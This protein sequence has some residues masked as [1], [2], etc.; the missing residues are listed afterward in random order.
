M[1]LYI[2][3]FVSTLVMLPQN[4][5]DIFDTWRLGANKTLTHHSTSSSTHWLVCLCIIANLSCLHIRRRWHRHSFSM[6]LPLW[7]LCIFPSKI[8]S[9]FLMTEWLNGW[10][11]CKRRIGS[12]HSISIIW[13]ASHSI[14]VLFAPHLRSIGVFVSFSAGAMVDCI[15]LNSTNGLGLSAAA[16]VV[17]WIGWMNF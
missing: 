10:R 11:R 4:K 13:F 2:Y 14:S 17:E 9:A 12:N 8:I 6:A 7:M 5:P 1:R 16:K 3:Y 15:Q